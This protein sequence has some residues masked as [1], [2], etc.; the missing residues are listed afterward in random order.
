MNQPVSSFHL[1]PFDVFEAAYLN[2]SNS[3]S[4]YLE[5]E[6]KRIHVNKTM[7]PGSRNALQILTDYKSSENLSTFYSHIH[8]KTVQLVSQDKPLTYPVCIKNE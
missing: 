3:Q 5:E 8:S 6:I 2:H 4:F 1:T 7:Q